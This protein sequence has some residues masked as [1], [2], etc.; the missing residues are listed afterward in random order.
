MDPPSH[1]AHER[2]C[3]IRSQAEDSS[4]PAG[5][6]PGGCH[7]R[8]SGHLQAKMATRDACNPGEVECKL[9]LLCD[10]FARGRERHMLRTRALASIT[11]ALA[12]AVFILRSHTTGAEFSS[13]SRDDPSRDA[14]QILHQLSSGSHAVGRTVPRDSGHR[15]PG[16]Q[17]RYVGEAGA[18]AAQPRDAAC[19]HAAARCGHLRRDR[20]VYRGRPRSPGGKV[21]PN[22]GRRTVHRLNQTGPG[23]PFAICWRSR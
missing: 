18:Q 16:G 23:M 19:R 11:I 9:P 2:A 7:R 1:E 20:Q 4:S 14:G 13:R 12:G 5:P 17:W 6:P 8:A 21:K 15:Q 3:S 10:P 22:P